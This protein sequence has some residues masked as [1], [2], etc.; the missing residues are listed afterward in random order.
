[1]HYF[2]FKTVQT[3]TLIWKPKVYLQLQS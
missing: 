2:I 1:M 3:V